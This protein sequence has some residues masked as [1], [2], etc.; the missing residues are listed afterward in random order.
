M[1]DEPL[2]TAT[3]PERV[4]HDDATPPRGTLRTP[5]P[6][7]SEGRPVPSG[8]SQLDHLIGRLESIYETVSSPYGRL[9]GIEARV[10]SLLCGLRS[11]AS[12]VMAIEELQGP[13]PPPINEALKGVTILIVD[14]EL[15]VQRSFARVVAAHGGDSLLANGGA[16]AIAVLDGGCA[17]N[18]ALVD[19]RLAPGYNGLTLC[20]HIREHHP[21]VGIVVMTGMLTTEEETAARE[22]N[23]RALE[24][25]CHNSQLVDAILEANARRAAAAAGPE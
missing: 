4:F 1:S 8:D 9:A 20:R 3:P 10:D 7:Y 17:V 18:V 25:P 6:A 15:L 16:K 5:L 2:E 19:L 11:L 13:M 22:M 12:V 21:G 23:I 24:K 14:D